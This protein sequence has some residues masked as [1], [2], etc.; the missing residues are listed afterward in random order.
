MIYS[1]SAILSTAVIALT[2][3]WWTDYAD[4]QLLEYYGYDFNA[5]SDSE[6]FEKV[7][8]GHLERVK[9]LQTGSMGIGWPLKVMLTYVFYTPYLVLVY[10]VTG[11]LKK[12]RAVHKGR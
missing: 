3:G 4:R 8:P 9:S 11:L 10:L 2:L 6:R 12:G 1:V 5:M 7:S